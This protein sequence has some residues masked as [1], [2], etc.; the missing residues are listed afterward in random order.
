MGEF[1]FTAQGRWGRLADTLMTPLMY[2]VQGTIWEH[3]QR[4]HFWNN[5]KYHRLILKD[6]ISAPI[7][8]GIEGDPE[9]TTRWLWG[10]VPRFH[11]PILGGWRNYIVLDAA[12]YEKHWHIGWFAEDGPVGISMIRL[13]TSVRVLR[14]PGAVHF[15]AI[16]ENAEQVPLRLVGKGKIGEAGE[17]AQLPLL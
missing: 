4:T 12:C 1:S 6:A 7:G 2:L 3:P 17:Y 11:I 9:A 5:H 10:F 14:G 8:V 16:D 13:T 15:F